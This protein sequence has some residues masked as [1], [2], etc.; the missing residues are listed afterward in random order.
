M[1]NNLMQNNR[2]E[3][4]SP[5]KK[6]FNFKSCKKNTIKSLNEI[7]CFLNDLHHFFHY[8]KIY[9]IFK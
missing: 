9:K 5:P 4:E 1:E 2:G 6:S 8:I 7:E 3:K